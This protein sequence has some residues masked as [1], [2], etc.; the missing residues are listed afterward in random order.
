MRQPLR[1]YSLVPGGFVVVS[2]STTPTRRP[3]G[4]IHHSDHG[5][6]EYALGPCLALQKKLM[7]AACP[8]RLCQLPSG[9][10]LWIVRYD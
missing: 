6:L 5:S 1:L 2:A 7:G 8:F 10:A 3:S 4:V 9:A